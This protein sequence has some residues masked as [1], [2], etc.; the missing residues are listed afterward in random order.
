MTLTTSAIISVA[1]NACS[2]VITLLVLAGALTGMDLKEKLNRIFI[3][4]LVLTL[5]G[6]ALQSLMSVLYSNFADTMVTAIAAIDLIDWT[7]ATIQAAM[8]AL[9]LY[10]FLSSRAKASKTPFIVAF[11]LYALNV[12]LV[13]VRGDD[14]SDVSI[15]LA[16][17]IPVMTML[18]AVLIVLRYA[19]LL[20]KREFLSLLL[21]LIFPLLL[22]LIQYARHDIW[23]GWLGVAVSTALMYINIHVETR[24]RVKEQ[25][26][27]MAE[28]RIAAMMS[29]MQPHFMYNMLVVIQEMCESD[30]ENAKASLEA[31]SRYL[32]VYFESLGQKETVPFEVELEHVKTY[33]SLEKTRFK[34][35]LNIVYEIGDIGFFIPPLTVQ[36]IAENAVRHGLHKRRGGMRGT[37]KIRVEETR[38]GNVITVEDDG[39]GF[40]PGKPLDDGRSH[41]GI[42]NVRER[43]KILCGG[44]LEYESAPGKGTKAVITIPKKGALT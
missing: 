19:R 17:V 3:T 42:Q 9:Y 25:E 13:A 43:L 12:L 27:A 32:H 1:G 28:S 33:L 34:D 40:A 4:M 35:K 29:Q 6:N 26:A 44:T 11:S 22:K 30:A 20:R 2:A 8:F 21:Y 41:I 36:P 38:R 24:T 7:F 18:I 37:V 14:L 39:V 31:F 16:G 23:L 15:R 5:T 10:V